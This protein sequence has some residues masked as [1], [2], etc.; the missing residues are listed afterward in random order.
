MLFL[1]E[2]GEW[3]LL[4]CCAVIAACLSASVSLIGRRKN[5]LRLCE[6]L[7]RAL[8]L[9]RGELALNA[10]PL[11]DLMAMASDQAG[12]QARF[13][14]EKLRAELS[15]IQ[16]KSFPQIWRDACEGSLAEMTIRDREEIE[17]LGPAL[18]RFT[19]EDQL[20]CCDKAIRHL[21]GASAAYRAAYASERR[22]I[23]ALGMSGGAMLCLL[24]I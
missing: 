15:G 7:C 10:P 1:E 11:Q 12:G 3:K 4:G 9:I 21:S 5:R 24:L 2:T 13:F 19:L 8:E 20:H 14:F 22:L 6:D 17:A 16:E 23:L 18:G